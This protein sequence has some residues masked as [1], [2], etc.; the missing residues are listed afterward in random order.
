VSER[1]MPCRMVQSVSEMDVHTLWNA[2]HALGVH[3][4][5]RHSQS[6][7]GCGVYGRSERR[8]SIGRRRRCPE[9][10]DGE[11]ATAVL[12]PKLGSPRACARSAPAREERRWGARAGVAGRWGRGGP[13]GRQLV[14]DWG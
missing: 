8:P 13:P 14:A 7:G 5:A 2:F 11:A 6:E 3:A 4:R 9:G 1:L 10:V 12:P